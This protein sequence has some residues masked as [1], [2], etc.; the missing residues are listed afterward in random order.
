[1]RAIVFDGSVRVVSDY[2]EPEAKAGEALLRTRVAGVCDTD[3][4]IVRGYMGFRGVLG[5]EFVADVLACDDPALTGRRVVGDINAG[6]GACDDCRLG[7]GHHCTTRTVLGIVGRNGAMAERFVLPTRN[8]VPVPN[9]V[10]DEAAVF[11][12]P[13]AAALHVIDDVEPEDRRVAVIGDG[14]L[15]LLVAL[16]LLSTT[17]EVVVF[18]HHASKLAI[19]ER[20]G[21]SVHA[22]EASAECAGRFP[23]VVEASGSRSGLQAALGLVAPRGKVILKTT[24]SGAF[25]IDLAP[26][27][28]HE[29]KV[30]GSRCGDVRKAMAALQA[31]AIDPSPLIEARFALSDGE[32]ALERASRKGALKVLIENR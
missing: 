32:A 10:S 17:R 18:G 8:L 14:K 16:A 4:Q 27:V 29:V 13:I 7:N 21:A 12:E 3:L 19:A 22:G 28:I 30:V 31:G 1:M 20:A 15:G 5:H 25:E 11:A 23:A 6:C 2:A 24:V 9:D 26:I